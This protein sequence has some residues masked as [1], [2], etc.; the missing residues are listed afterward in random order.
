MTKEEH[1][2]KIKSLFE[3]IGEMEAEYTLV[4]MAYIKSYSL[5]SVGDKVKVV[6][7]PRL[8]EYSKTKKTKVRI[9]YGYVV[10]IGYT[11]DYE[12]EYMLNQCDKQGFKSRYPL[13][14]NPKV[15]TLEKINP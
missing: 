7:P 9:E 12:L 5:F 6:T 8:K 14:Y 11:E 13:M 3:A 15:C 10:G 4:R 2:A 1:K